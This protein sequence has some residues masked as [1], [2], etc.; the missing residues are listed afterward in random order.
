MGK[1]IVFGGS[2][3]LG[4][5]VVRAAT[6]AGHEAVVVGRSGRDTH[7]ARA[8]AWDAKTL[9]PWTSELEGATAV[10]NLCGSPVFQRWTSAGK[11]DIMESRVV[12]TRLLGEAIAACQA[13]PSV[14]VNASATGGYGDC[15]AREVSEASGF[16]TGFLAEVCKEWEGAM[17][18]AETPQTARCRLRIGIV[19]G[20]GC[21]FGKVIS[22]LPAIGPLGSGSNYQ[23][24][25]HVDDVASMALFA[26]EIGFSG[27]MN[28]TAPTP[29]TNAAL[30]EAVRKALVRL[31]APP[32]PDSLVG[33]A[34]RM[35]GW[36]K[37]LLTDSCRAVP[38]IALARGFQFKYPRLEQAAQDAFGQAPKAW[39]RQLA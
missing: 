16:G 5:A 23:P 15:G 19:L 26:I 1:I 34:C 4:G 36:D 3:Y 20:Q 22:R 13:A 30:M 12:P 8:V 28:A 10:V 11:R 21:P 31:P 35:S 7:G 37:E 27:A 25:I 32:L 6:A 17:L 29:A 14:W 9:G 2:G 33:L 38:Q 39:Q 18:A 24:W